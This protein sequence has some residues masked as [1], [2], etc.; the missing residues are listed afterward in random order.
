MLTGS[1]EKNPTF[2][3]PSREVFDSGQKNIQVIGPSQE[4]ENAVAKSHIGFW[5][6]H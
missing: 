2:S 4:L 6:K 3:M 5:N 1:A